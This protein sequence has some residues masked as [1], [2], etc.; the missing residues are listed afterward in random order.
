MNIEKQL[1]NTVARAGMKSAC[2]LY[3]V[4]ACENLILVA[5]NGIR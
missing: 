2:I 1:R 4:L 3:S 5:G